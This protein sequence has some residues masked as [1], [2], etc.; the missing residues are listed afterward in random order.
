[1]RLK[2]RVAIVTGG[3]RGIGE[4]IAELFAKEGA[5]VIII[6][7]LPQGKEVAERINNNGGAAS[8]QS[9]SVTDKPA[10]E[11]LFQN[12]RTQTAFFFWKHLYT[13]KW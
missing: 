9:I 11:A 10:I 4:A 7:L 12:I 8:Y 5:K 2:D 6:D 1:M 3:A 13:S